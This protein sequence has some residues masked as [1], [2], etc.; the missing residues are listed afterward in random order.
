MCTGSEPLV[1]ENDNNHDIPANTGK[2]HVYLKY[3]ITTPFSR[4]CLAYEWLQFCS[5][6]CYQIV[7]L[8]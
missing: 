6:I 4:L 2:T 7:D 8:R 1:S 3:V 5:K